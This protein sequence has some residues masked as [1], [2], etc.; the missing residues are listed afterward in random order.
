M[1]GRLT[2]VSIGLATTTSMAAC[3]G[4]EQW[5]GIST[6]LLGAVA[7][8][9][10]VFAVSEGHLLEGLGL[11]ALGVGLGVVAF[12][13]LDESLADAPRLERREVA[14][15]LSQGHGALV[16]DFAADLGLSQTALPHLGHVLRSARRQLTAAI[17]A[18]KDGSWRPFFVALRTII[19]KDET[20][21]PRLAQ[22][23]ARVR[24]SLLGGHQ[25]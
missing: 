21:A 15:A 18:E 5:P 6:G 3:A 16:T 24:L 14:L 20:L 8:S 23:E 9:G 19:S 12:S 7:L 10:G 1:R 11:T 13:F 25:R 4:V 17:P 22:L 2:M